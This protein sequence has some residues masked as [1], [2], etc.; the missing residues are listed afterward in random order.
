MFAVLADN[1]DNPKGLCFAPDGSLYVTEAGGGGE[2][3]GVPSPSGQGILYYGT[4]GSVTRIE[5]G[6]AERVLT[7]LPSV[8]F[9]DGTG[10]A[11]PHDI[12]FDSTGKP[13]VL[14]GYAADPALRDAKL[15]ETDLGKI[16]TPDFNTNS[17]TTIADLA[18]YELANNP[19]QAE[20]VSNPLALL[21]DEGKIIVVDAGANDLLRVNTDGSHLH[22]IAVIPKQTLINPIFPTLDSQSF[23]RGHVPPPSAYRHAQPSQM[24]IQ[25]VPTG[26]AKGHDG[27]YYISEFTGFP[28]PEGGAKIYRLSSEGELKTYVEG[29]TQLI[30]LAFD[31]EGNLYTLEHAN[32][33]GWKGKLDGTLIKIAADGTRTTVLSGN[34]LESPTAL[35]IGADGAIYVIN[36]GGRPKQGQV[37][38][39]KNPT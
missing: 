20:V 31:E 30:D 24:L 22:A 6:K 23:D 15:G 8:A 4:S 33:S 18:D 2:V 38:R 32:Q 29:F 12:K 28:F 39:I 26:I 3:V 25:S 27:A 13:Y 17:W 36:R 5:N 16:I 21:I 19:D 7:G 34:G 10:A 14:I 9:P 1:L 35:T 37:I 11:G